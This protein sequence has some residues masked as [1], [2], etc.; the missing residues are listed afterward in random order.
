MK[1]KRIALFA[2]VL[3]AS[4]LQASEPIVVADFESETYGEW[5]LE[6]DA[7]GKGPARGKIG[8]Q[9]EVLGFLG[10]G[11]VNSFNGGDNATGKLT[12][13][14]FKIQRKF[15][16]FLIGGGGWANETCMNLLVDGK[17]VR[18]ATGPNIQSGGSEDLKTAAWDVTEFAGRNATLVIV[19]QR[20][21]GWG[22]ICIDQIVQ[23]DDRGNVPLAA[24]VVPPPPPAPERSRTV[25][26]TA[27]FLQ[28]PLMRREE[29]M[30]PGLEKLT[31]MLDG[32]VV[33]TFHA[34]FPPEGQEPDFRY[35]YDLREFK[36]QEVTLQFKSTDATVLD[37]LELSD[38]EFIDPKAYT[39]ENRPRFHFSPRLGWMN[40]VN[41]TYYQDGLYHLF[42]QFNPTYNGNAGAGFDMHW[43]HS[44]S[45][46]LVHWEEW[47]VALFPDAAG[48]CY[49]G[50]T[51]MQ[52]H[53]IPGINEGVKLPSPAVF[54]AATN[55]FSQHLATTPDGGRT[56]KRFAGNPVVPNI[57]KGDRDP[58]VVWHEASQ[59]YIMVLYVGGTGDKTD[60]YRF[61]RS[62]DLTHWEQTSELANW[63][64]CPEFVPVKSAVTGEDLMLLYGCYR[65]PKDA[66]EQI[67]IRS[68][69]QLGRFDGKTFTPITKLRSAHLG[70]NYYAA[71]VFMNEPKARAVMMGW[72][73]GT[74][75]PDEPFNQCAS[76]PLL[77][78][79]KAI[80]G[81]DTLCFEP[82]E[83]VDALRGEPLLKLKNITTAEA[84][85]KLATLTKE[86]SLDVVMRVRTENASSVRV[87]IRSVDFHYDAARMTLKRA[88]QPTVLHAGT[89]MDARFLIDRGIVESF[90]NGGEAA[91]SAAS[92]HTDAGPAFAIDGDALIEELAV[93]PMANIWAPV[94]AK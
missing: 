81:E 78:K 90:W 7:F 22:H 89:V 46:D 57:G 8:G 54:L 68:C 6:G 45:K 71:L 60:T 3:S 64:E 79:I 15:F 66:P 41:G 86:A 35:S 75:F 85:A 27:D 61:M 26:I 28:L 72:A 19:D 50:S 80:N 67:N 58:K 87:K 48:Q 56:W 53:P 88:W 49:S 32:R 82:A 11:L 55:P 92:L 44:V 10:K 18:T 59:H 62:K 24:V 51:V 17:V 43:G 69:Y 23:T 31:V 5:K 14:E 70:P 12:S 2:A 65:T 93:Y 16:T 63:F 37:R 91:Y 9:Q 13:P 83:E 42:Y 74:K 30:K 25:K 47:P 21:G 1:S 20:K 39:G 29:K 40:D 52:Q 84:T 38:R 36:G 33:R 34:E 73:A 4:P 94:R 77:M 76:V